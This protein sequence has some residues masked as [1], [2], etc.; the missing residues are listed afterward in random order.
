MNRTW[1]HHGGN[2]LRAHFNQ[3][4]HRVATAKAQRTNAALAASAFQLVNQRDQNTRATC[5]NGVAKR[6]AA[7]ANVQLLVRD[8][9]RGDIGQHLRGERL[10]HF[11]QVNVFYGKIVFLQQHFNAKFGRKE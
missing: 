2:F 8:T 6:N 5:A 4:T 1:S 10:V 7:A 3:H 11:E 9:K